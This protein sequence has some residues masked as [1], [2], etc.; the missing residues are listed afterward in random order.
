MENSTPKKKQKEFLAYNRF[1]L[2]FDKKALHDFQKFDCPI[3]ERIWQKLRECKEYPF[4]Y[5]EKLVECK[6]FK[7]RVCDWR[8]LADIDRTKGTI[9]L[10][11][12]GHR[13]NV[14]DK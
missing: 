3:K 1:T 14:Y 13:K 8:I 12:I 5:F 10:F 11:K 9:T 2:I 4:R 7:L 6:G